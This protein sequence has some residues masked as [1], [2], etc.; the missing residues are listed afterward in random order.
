MDFW[1]EWKEMGGGGGGGGGG[2]M[3]N[4]F[5]CKPQ[6]LLS[7]QRKLSVDTEGKEWLA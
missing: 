3:A 6:P 1:T 4:T 5:V 2:G 7:I